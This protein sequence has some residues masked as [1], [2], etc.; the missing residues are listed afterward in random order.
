MK[1]L[2]NIILCFTL[3]GIC[4]S[5][6][7]DE[8][9]SLR[10]K[11]AE[12]KSLKDY[13]AVCEY[14]YSQES[15]AE[16]LSAYADSIMNLHDA[17]SRLDC[18]IEFYQWKGEA[19]FQMG[20]QAEGFTLK[21]CAYQYAEE[22]GDLSYLASVAS[23]IGYYYNIAAKYD[24]A[25][26]YFDQALT[27]CSEDMGCA[28]AVRAMLSN[29]ASSYLMEGKTD[30]ALV[31][32]LK[33]K[34]RSLADGDTAMLV[35]N[36][37]QLGT[38]FRRKKDLKKSIENFE[39]AL[40]YCTVQNNYS[41]SAYIYGNL[42]TVYCD[43]ERIPEAIS[44]SQKAVELAEKLGYPQMVA[45]CYINLGA[46]QCK[47][48]QQRA[49]GI[50]MLEKAVP[51]LMKLGNGRRLC[52]AYN[53]LVNA[54]RHQGDL[55][56][57]FSYL[58]KLDA[59]SAEMKTDVELYRYYDAK[60]S[61][62]KAQHNFKEALPYYR[63]IIDMQS[64][65]YADSRDYDHYI[66]LAECLH[67]SHADGEAY[68]TLL[69]G[70]SLRDSAYQREKMMQLSD[71]SIKYETQEKEVEILRLQ[72]H[73]LE[74]QSI[75]V[76]N[77]VM[78]G[79]VVILMAVALL[80][81]LYI[82]QR[83]KMSISLMK[84]QAGERERKFLL[85]QKDTEQRLTHKYIDGLEYER[86]RIA[87]ELHDDVC[88]SLLALEMRVQHE[89]QQEEPA[90]LM[91]SLKQLS[92]IRQRLRSL[93]HELVPPVFQYAT[94]DEMLSDYLSHIPD[95]LHLSV[96]YEST[97]G[98]SWNRIK[99]EVCFEY[100]RIVQEAMGNI[101]KHSKATQAEVKLEYQEGKLMLVIADNGV[102]YDK[103]NK[104][105]GIGLSTM[106]KRAK[107]IGASFDI[108]SYPGLGTKIKVV[109]KLE[110]DL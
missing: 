58:Q 5:M 84:Q 32:T 55:T 93:S 94:I 80:V 20:K 35:E 2:Y 29:Y 108:D 26:Y 77:Y 24:S 41:T 44:F 6:Q 16:M 81:L 109:V 97:P 39:K 3:F 86:K 45:N 67:E 88:N 12:S 13:S 98:V 82:R 59:L 25:R 71:F 65:G 79:I 42:A 104:A 92:G 33:A 83:Q 38:L 90:N 15:D 1:T 4:Q 14:L 100:Y 63:K 34:E 11:A 50:R 30:S 52:E 75:M 18:L 78:I 7:A 95:L 27:V 106:N 47:L 49:D 107:A 66:S 101:I 37:N 110:S 60:A 61:L 89:L 28:V 96:K 40:H 53:H 19:A 70:L 54:Y 8:L 22:L 46:I 73:R 21:R 43:W 69:R 56:N 64:R 9:S 99:K 105:P 91:E 74:Q 23:D 76:R 36:Y 85:L 87:T 10:Q 102:G 51:I 31:W 68:Q 72:Q 103:E 48:D 57:A 17:D 62:L